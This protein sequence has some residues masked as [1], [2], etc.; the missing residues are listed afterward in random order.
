DS[1][2]VTEVDKQF[3]V[4]YMVTVNWAIVDTEGYL[5]T[6][7]TATKSTVKWVSFSDQNGSDTKDLGNGDSYEIQAADAERYIGI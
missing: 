4:G 7:N 2:I 6:D 3:H 5:D 1:K